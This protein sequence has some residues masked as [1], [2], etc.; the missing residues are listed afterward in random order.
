MNC[1]KTSS[2]PRSDKELRFLCDDCLTKAVEKYATICAGVAR[3]ECRGDKANPDYK[4]REA[5]RNGYIKAIKDAE[6]RIRA[7]LVVDGESP[8]KLREAIAQRVA[9]LGKPTAT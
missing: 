4:A 9:D 5:A 1:G 8:T 7:T 2:D 6:E 3:E